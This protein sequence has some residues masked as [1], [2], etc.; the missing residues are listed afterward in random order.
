M[1]EKKH[2]I[3]NKESIDSKDDKAPTLKQTMASVGSAMI[4]IQ[5]N[6]NRKRDFSQGK[7]SHFVIAGVLGVVLFISALVLI[8]SL[9][10]PD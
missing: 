7:F 9:V 2:F 1:T 10:L 3:S 4:G 6:K 5:S 8:V